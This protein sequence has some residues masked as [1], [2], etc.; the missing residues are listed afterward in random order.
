MQFVSINKSHYSTSTILHW[1]W[2]QFKDN[3]VQATLNTIIGIG[4]VALDLL[5]VWATKLTIDIATH[6]SQAMPLFTSGLIL[7][8]IILLQ[9]SISFAD[10]WIRAI[11]GVKAQN[12]MQRKIYTHIMNCEWSKMI[13]FHSGDIL[14]RIEKDVTSLVDFIT[15]SIPSLIT[16][17][18]KLVGAFIFLFMMDK[19]LACI[20]IVIAPTF[21]LI[22]KLYIHKMRQLSREV[23]QS[24]SEIQSII[25]ES[26]QHST[27]IKTL[28]RTSTLV[29]RLM[30]VQNIMHCQVRNRTKYSAISSTIMNIGFAA[31]YLFTFLWGASRLEQGLITYGALMAFIQLVGQIQGPARSLTSFIP[32]I[33]ST[34]TSTERI[35]ELQE[36]PKEKI[37]PQ[38]IIKT[39]IGVRFTNVN[40]DYLESQQI[41][42]QL[43]Y[44]FKP[45]SITAVMGETGV[46]KTTLIRLMLALVKPKSG[47]VVLYDK[48]QN[49]QEITPFSRRYFSYVPQGNT[50]LSGTIRSNLLLGNPDA[51][52][53]QLKDSLHIANADFVFDFD[54]GLDTICSEQGIR[55]SE[56]Q[57]QRIC[58]ARALLRPCQ[59]L[60]LDEATS[61]LDSK[62]ETTVLQNLS[63]YTQGKTIIVIS[64]RKAIL[65]YCDDVLKL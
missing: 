54:E 29:N 18:F 62:T 14:N 6:Q 45:N 26:I 32:V 19:M 9:I 27:V 36:I 16:I 56:G 31:G 52:E 1:I 37:V 47:K 41:F 35:L 61:A 22:S 51:T 24:D 28:E 64:H 10:K 30:H 49:E 8:L 34:F 15:E 48:D 44:D 33:I 42:H 39:T 46:G 3:R 23:R 17:L 50:L 4:L 7:L 25:Q 57:A 21:I 60:L 43:S 5:F 53:E 13:K 20:I 38:P 55:L 58:L 63:S 59:I 2:T 12:Q 11:L 65:K 40:Y